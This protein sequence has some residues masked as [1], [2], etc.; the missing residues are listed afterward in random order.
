MQQAHTVGPPLNSS[1]MQLLMNLQSG[2]IHE[3]EWNCKKTPHMCKPPFNCHEWTKQDT[4]DIMMNGLA[5]RDGHANLRSWCLPGLER[6]A[7]GFL[8]ECIVNKDLMKSAQV[9][10]TRTFGDFADELD[11]S[12]CFAEGHCTNNVVTDYSTVTDGEKM[13]DWRFGERRG[14]TRNFLK[15]Q[16][17]LFAMPKALTG[18]VSR[19]HGFTTQR[20]TRTITK[21]ACAQG[22]FHCDVQ[23]CKH[24]YCSDEYYVNKY[25]HL[26]PPMPGNLIRDPD[27]HVDSPE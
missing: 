3:A 12:Y 8:K 9:A 22:T 26:L 15:A 25:S 17:R 7:P 14:W 21:M 11:A 23:H 20:L 18:L 24:T 16:K 1:R 10:F 19:K 5:T 27:R 2:I 4:L 6:Y 13:C